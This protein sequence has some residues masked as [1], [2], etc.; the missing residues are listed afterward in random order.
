MLTRSLTQAVFNNNRIRLFL[1]N[2]HQNK[3][4][5]FDCIGTH[6]PSAARVRTV[7][8]VIITTALLGTAN[9]AFAGFSIWTSTTANVIPGTKITQIDGGPCSVCGGQF[10]QTSYDTNGFL[11]SRGLQT[12]RTEAFGT[13]DARTITTD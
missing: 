3:I 11:A 10:N 7:C 5:L 12:S 9:F 4:R 8:K 13:P 1:T 6:K 2:T